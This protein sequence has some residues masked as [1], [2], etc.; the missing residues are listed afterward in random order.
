MLG[1]I[2]ETLLE[3]AANVP[4]NCGRREEG[5]AGG[6][7]GNKCWWILGRNSEHLS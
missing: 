7:G 2:T 5:R 6:L 3:F 1:R 4:F